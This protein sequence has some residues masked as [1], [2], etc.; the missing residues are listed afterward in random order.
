MST[1]P[2]SR[3]PPPARER[4]RG[5]DLVDS[6]VRNRTV[7]CVNT[8][9]IA[10]PRRARQIF[11]AALDDA[12]AKFS[13]TTTCPICVE[14]VGDAR[15]SLLVA[16]HPPTAAVRLGHR[17]CTGPR[18]RHLDTLPLLSSSSYDYR[19]AMLPVTSGETAGAVPAVL[20]RIGVDQALLTAVDGRWHLEA[21]VD[22]DAAGFTALTGALPTAGPPCVA[23]IDGAQLTVTM[24]D[25]QLRIDDPQFTT[26]TMDAGALL[27]VALTGGD[28]AE[29]TAGRLVTALH[30]PSSRLA[31]VGVDTQAVDCVPAAAHDSA[32]HT[33]PNQ[34]STDQ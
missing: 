33:L 4:R 30:H 13:A 10:L 26:V 25:G 27:V 16:L 14:P 1:R 9:R 23:T 21:D 5:R 15:A 31:L 8:H 3:P 34:E 32:G 22:W 29:M 2:G 11:G 20:L 19:T 7:E 24:P 28:L 18:V 12:L 17:S 6:G